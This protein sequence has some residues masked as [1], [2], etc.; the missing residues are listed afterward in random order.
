MA[1]TLLDLLAVVLLAVFAWFVWE[2]LPLLV[3]GVSCLL[4]S[5]RASRR[6]RP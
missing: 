5:E 4:I 1:T 6:R 3:V 2:P